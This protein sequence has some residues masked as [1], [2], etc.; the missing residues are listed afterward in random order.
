L[1][2]YRVN[3]IKI[4]QQFMAGVTTEPGDAAIVRAA[5]GLAR[6]LGMDAIAEGVDDAEQLAFLLAAG[7]R[8][9]QG[10]YF[11]APVSADETG[12]LLRQGEIV[13]KVALKPVESPPLAVHG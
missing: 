5:L 8:Y 3:R 9:A 2:T 13:R 7:C 6:E 4:A 1:R 10:R 12:K 11:S